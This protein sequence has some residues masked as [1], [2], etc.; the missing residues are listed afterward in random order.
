MPKLRET[1]DILKLEGRVDIQFPNQWTK[2]KLMKFKN[3]KHK[4]LHLRRKN[5]LLEQRRVTGML[6]SSFF[7][8]DLE[9]MLDKKLNINQRCAMASKQS[10]IIL[11][12]LNRNK[13]R[14]LRKKIISDCSE[15]V[16]LHLDTTTRFPPAPTSLV[17][18]K[19]KN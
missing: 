9:V 16:R 7:E 17:T 1:V 6:K 14:K 11:G 4:V 3:N 5:L 8:K 13:V 18:K 19:L 10:K 2:K 15:L 12:Y